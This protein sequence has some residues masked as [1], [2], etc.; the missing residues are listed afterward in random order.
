MAD[1]RTLKLNLL[2]DVNDFSKGL[3]TAQQKF[4][5][6]SDSVDKYAQKAGIA[7][8]ALAGAGSLMAKSAAE[9]EASQ[10][11]LA[12]ELE[13]TIGA[14]KGQIA[15]VEDYINVTALATGVA[16]DQLRPAYQRLIRS[17]KDTTEAQ[18]LMNLALDISTATG[19]DYTTVAEALAKANDGNFKSLK[20]LGITLGDNANNAIE[21]AA[22]NNKLIKAQNELINI[23]TESGNKSAEYKKQAE[24][25]AEAQD[26]VNSIFQQGIDWAGELGKQFG[27]QMATNTETAAGQLRVLNNALSEAK[28]SIGYALLPVMEKF[29]AKVQSAIPF[30]QNN[31][32]AIGKWGVAA[33]VLTGSLYVFNGVLKLV[34][35]T[36][37]AFNNIVKLATA[38]Q[39]AF[40]FVM[41]L[42]PAALVAI[43]IIALGA[44]FVA[45][46]KNIEPFRD[47]IDSIWEKMK[48]LLDTIKNSAIAGAVTRAFNA[49]TGR[50]SG[51]SVSAGTA[52]TVG[53]FGKEVFVPS[54]NGRIIPNDQLG[55]N[56]T[57]NLNGIIDAESARRS[58][59]KLLQDSARR[60]GAINLVGA[61][62]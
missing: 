37:E 54:T 44:A 30:I 47:L 57:I 52:Y 60:T 42:N 6:F 1:I 28:E 15:A 27:G 35:G 43:A 58:I 23:Q 12:K 22:A 59:E 25:V 32:D 38:A 56:V 50:A 26:K 45:A 49:V 14:T 19:N 40:N 31:A 55:G 41:G 48:R 11:K 21:Y 13:N 7:F 10:I 61:T 18:K 9:D 29:V 51:G 8:A 17:T 16:D 53:E 3:E 33:A 2:A 20:K 4:K 62:L 46:Y 24:K 34:N 36:F 5:G 39:A